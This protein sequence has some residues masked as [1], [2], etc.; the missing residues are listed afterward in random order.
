MTTTWHRLFSLHEDKTLA[1]RLG[2]SLG[3][4]EGRLD[5]R[6]FPDGES[7][8]R[9]LDDVKHRN[10]V[11]LADLYQ[12]DRRILP[13]L[14]LAETLRDLGAREI[15]LVAPY[16]P[17]MRQ[18]KR[19]HSGEGVTS[20]YF[21]KLLSHYFS[22]L[23]TV[24]PHLH[25]YHD[26][27]EIY[28]IPARVG[29]AAPL[30]AEWIAA[31]IDKPVLIGPDSESEQ[32]VSAVARQAGAP[33]TVLSKTRRGDRDVE[34]S[35]PQIERWRNHTPVLVDD[36]I[37]SGHTML[38]TLAHLKHLGLPDAVCLAVHGVFAEGADEKLTAVARRVVTSNAI[39]HSTNAIDIG[40]LLADSIRELG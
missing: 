32:W 5:M 34:V 29:H 21:A 26:L 1:Q 12:P 22:A 40:D 3:L 7:Y 20:R 16:L 24:D 2:E 18:D 14:L 13:L 4:E 8:L 9:I 30:I 19:F 27:S 6:H 39:P 11:V 23:V 28:D 35:V 10:V 33:F 31:N 25:R 17:Y 37:S 38:E 15:L 36:I